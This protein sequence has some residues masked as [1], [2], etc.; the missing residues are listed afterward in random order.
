VRAE[1]GGFVGKIGSVGYIL[2]ILDGD[3][4]DETTT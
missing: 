4:A 2:A 1:R 3:S